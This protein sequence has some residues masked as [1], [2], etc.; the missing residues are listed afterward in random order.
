MPSQTGADRA[1]LIGDH[2]NP[3]DP[4]QNHARWFVLGIRGYGRNDFLFERFPDDT[5]WRLVT[6]IP[7]EVKGFKY[8]K[9]GGCP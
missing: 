2:A 8:A 1:T 6:V 9:N 5:V 4:E 7:D 3:K